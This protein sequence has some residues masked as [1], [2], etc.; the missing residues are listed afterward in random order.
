LHSDGTG[1]LENDALDTWAKKNYVVEMTIALAVTLVIEILIVLIWIGFTKRR[2][3]AG[4]VILVAFAGNL[5]T[6]PAVWTASLM[7]KTYFDFE[8]A[9]VIYSVAEVGA[10]LVEG[11]LYAW[12]GRFPVWNAFLLSF[13]A[14]C[15]SFLCG[16]CLV[17]FY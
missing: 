2:A 10:F 12:L 8:T 5:I 6:V 1:T 14:N 7:G 4:R 16:C 3:S 9:V 15:A 17:S 13:T 11:V